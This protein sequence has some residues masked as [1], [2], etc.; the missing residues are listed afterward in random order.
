MPVAFWLGDRM[1]GKNH[2]IRVDFTLS[3]FDQAFLEQNRIDDYQLP[4][5]EIDYV[6]QD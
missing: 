4:S 1:T 2:P 6:A 3:G 5:A